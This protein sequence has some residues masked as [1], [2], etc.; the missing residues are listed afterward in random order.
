VALTVEDGTGLTDANAFI[1]VAYAD[2]Y[3]SD[4]GNTNWTGTTAD[5]EAAIIKATDYV[6]KRFKF[7]FK[8]FRKNREQSLSWPRI[9][10]FD[11]DGFEYGDVPSVL[12]MGIAEYALRTMVHGELSPDVPPTVPRQDNTTLDAQET[13]TTTGGQIIRYT[14]KVAGIT[15]TTTQYATPS[16]MSST[17][18]SRTP[19]AS[20]VSSVSIPEYPAADLLIELLLK[21]PTRSVNLVLG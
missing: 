10:A 13:V 9:G 2:T 19:Q 15:E 21:S 16:R 20:V 8:G 7:K 4:R 6:E 5:K 14:N 11:P 1:S 17:S 12:E 18:V 3:H